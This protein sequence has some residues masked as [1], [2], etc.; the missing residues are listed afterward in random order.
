MS[1][2]IFP[3]AFL[4]WVFNGI[5]VAF[6]QLVV[7]EVGVTLS[8]RYVAVSCEFLGK[9]KV[10]RRSQHPGNKVMSEGMGGNCAQSLRSQ[11]FI[12]PLRHDIATGGGGDWLYLF[13]SPLIM[14]G[15]KR[16]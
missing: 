6:I 12:D 11:G 3:G 15:K 14:S 9:F 16:K 7:G 5:D 10:T 13:S 8:H 1:S 2:G 4:F